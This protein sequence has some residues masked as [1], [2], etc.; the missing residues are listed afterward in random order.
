MKPKI[1]NRTFKVYFGDTDAAQVVH[2]ARYLYWLEAARI[3]YLDFIGC[4]YT[5]LQAKHIGLMPIDINIQYKKSLQFADEFYIT[6]T[7]NKLNKASCILNGDIYKNKILY[8][9]SQ[10]KL[11]CVDETT[12]KPMPLP[13][14]LTDCFYKT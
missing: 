1:F 9:S 4:P 11:A 8:C 7:L 13:K 6:I 3:D 14:F 5:Q 12:W 10:I 2:H